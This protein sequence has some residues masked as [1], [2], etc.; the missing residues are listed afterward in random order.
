MAAILRFQRDISDSMER[1]MRMH[2][3]GRSPAAK[4]MARALHRARM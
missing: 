4:S 2:G 3:F 1:K